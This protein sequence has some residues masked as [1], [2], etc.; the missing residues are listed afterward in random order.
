M[1]N[2]LEVY[3]TSLNLVARIYHL[4]S[5]FPKSEMYGLAS[6]INRA[7]TSIPL[8]IAEGS[9][10]RS[11]KEYAHFLR[12]ALGSATEIES[13]FD[14]LPIVNLSNENQ[15][16]ELRFTIHRIRKMLLSIIKTLEK[17]S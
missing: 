10:R 17:Q 6:Q 7:S 15:L 16:K 4:S 11:K 3:K 14:V 5:T 2:K 9:S 13:L 1:Y 8:N 12:I